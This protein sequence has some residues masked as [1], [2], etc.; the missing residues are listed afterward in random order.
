MPRRWRLEVDER[1][2][3]DG[4][5]EVPLDP[6][7]LSTIAAEIADSDIEAVAVVFL[8]AHV[9][10]A[11]E[12]AALDELRHLLPGRFV[13]AS[14]EVNP[15][16]MEY[17]R[18]SST[19]INA[20]LGPVCGR[21]INRLGDELRRTGFVGEILF[22][23]S[24]G[25]LARPSVVAD[26]PI[27]ILESGPAGGVS[28]AA[29]SCARSDIGNAILGDMGGT[30]FDVSLIRDFRPEVR[31]RSLLHTYTVRS[32]TIDIDSVGA[33]GGSIGWID[34]AGGVHIGPKSAAADP[35]P[36]CYG[37]GGEEATV[38]DCNL[39]LG[40]LDA[41]TFLGGKFRLDLD[42]A[43]R[44]IDRKI[45][46]PLG[47]GVLEAAQTVRSV[48]N[49]VMAQAIRIMTVE[50]GYDPRD[51]AYICYGGAGPVHALDLAEAI[52]IQTV[53]VPPMP[54]LFSAVGM[55]VAAQQYHFQ[56]PV[57]RPLA[58][59]TDASIAATFE[60]LA[61][62]AMVEMRGASVGE[63][64]VRTIRRVDCRYAGQPESITFDVVAADGSICAAIR[65]DFE[66]A[67]LRQWNFANPDKAIIVDNVR[68]QVV[69]PAGWDGEVHEGAAAGTPKPRAMRQVYLDNAL[70]SLPVY[71]RADIPVGGV[72]KGEAVIEEP[73]SSM[74]LK[75]SQVARVDPQMNLV[76]ELA[77]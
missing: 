23:Q 61:G 36:A 44:A 31:N 47:I 59:L 71:R 52:G 46:R 21:Y 12:R 11:H 75:V 58:Q 14:H 28:A 63:A 42:A 43:H 40:Y 9:N 50:R 54:G 66:A 48:A 38:T 4:S 49:A 72:L 51:F 64:N 39:V 32:P 13:S 18:T 62:T 55:I 26:K 67:H 7:A 34:A 68:I 25:G 41:D 17:E 2:R 57:D 76:I 45:A 33:G 29:R 16:V 53:I 73:S 22:M 15:E 60:Q 70:R 27:L 8:H 10:P 6:A 74:V 65:R 35:G 77:A 1:L 20:M 24:N 30:T 19:V 3:F 56:A 5:V 69:A 37:R